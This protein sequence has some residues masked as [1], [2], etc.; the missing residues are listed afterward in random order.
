VHRRRSRYAKPTFS[1][2]KIILLLAGLVL[3]VLA[4]PPFFDFPWLQFWLLPLAAIYLLL[5]LMLPRL[6]LIVLPLATVG[7]DITPWTGRFSYNE[8]DLLFLVTLASGLIYGRYRFKVFSPSVAMIVSLLYLVLIAVGYNG[9]T[10]FVIPP[11]AVFGNPYYSSEYAYKVLKGLLW[12]ASLVPMWGYLLAVNKQKAVN[13]LACGMSLAAVL[14]GLI[15]LWERGTL[16]VLLSWSAWYHIVSS[17]LD[18]TSS[19]RVTGI[20]S[21]MHT[22]GEAIDGVL[23]LLLPVTLYSAVYGRVVW[24]RLLGGLGFLAV[25]YVTLVG[26]TRATYAAFAFGVALFAVLA[27]W[28]RR[29]SGISLSFSLAWL[30]ATL[31]V[32][33]VIAVI[34]FRFAGS[35]G[36]AS[37]SVLLLLAYAANRLQFPGYYRHAAT[38]V[39]IL[40]VALAVNAH[41]SSRW[42]EPSFTAAM[43]LAAGLAMVYIIA[44][45]LFRETG[46][47]QE[48][49][50]LFVLGATL[51]L[52]IILAFAVGGHQIGDRFT[53]VSSD[54][55]TRQSHW[56]DVINSADPGLLPSMI[57]NGAGTF[58]ARY[59]GAH[60]QR[61]QDVGSFSIVEQYPGTM[62]QLGGGRDL[63][64]GQRLGIAP[65][66]NYRID[67]QIRAAQPGRLSIALCERNLIYAS[68]FMSSCAREALNF[69]STNKAL[70]KYTLEINSGRVGE[71]GAFRRWPTVLTLNYGKGDA[72]LEIDS[73]GLSADGFNQTRNNLFESGMDYWFFYNDISHLPWHV[74]NIFLQLWFKNGWLG[75]GFFLSL[76]ALLIRV[77]FQRHAHDSLLPVYTTGVITLCVFGLFGSPLDSAR[78]S[79]MFYFFL[80]SGLARL[81]MKVASNRAH[82]STQVN[83]GS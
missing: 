50:R 13:A 41:F 25:A 61:V 57:G 1:A 18:L 4:M 11:Q 60:P 80:F 55:D 75:L 36:L 14:L 29:R 72:V 15:V 42:V 34:A 22:G 54:L 73:I 66:T 79:W 2:G 56:R 28:L 77:N 19:Y 6:W 76:V 16:G 3:L 5:L 53:R 31:G 35:Y 38:G 83:Q 63:T 9:W 27:I 47:A 20:F 26:F 45:K 21:D 33:V 37:F 44:F 24:L 7:F 69:E 10:M 68:N 58:P 81:R 32:G 62:L 71:R 30:S 67:V 64:I 39:A 12:G 48:I 52:P 8:I 49:E 74:K 70:T 43:V 17:L 82:S 23:L 40:L 46:E 51:A 78:V 59:I 65:Y